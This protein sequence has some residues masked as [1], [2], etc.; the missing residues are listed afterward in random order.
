[1]PGSPRTDPSGHGSPHSP[2]SAAPAL[3]VALDG[4]GGAGKSTVAREV[5]RRRGLR[6][7]DTGSTYR[8][9]TWAVLRAG[10]D[11]ADA[12]AVAALLPQVRIDVTTDAA[13]PGTRVDGL[14]VAAA[15][16]RDDVS[17]GVSAVSAV[18]AVRRALV[19]L[20]QEEVARALAVP[21]LSGEQVGIVVEGRDTGA[22]VVPDA[23][24]KVFLTAD[25]A[26]RAR[27]RATERGTLGADDVRRTAVAL[28]RRDAADSGRAVAPLAVAPG[29][30]VVDTTELSLEEAVSRVLDLLPPPPGAGPPAVERAPRTDPRAPRARAVPAPY[31]PRLFRVL[32]VPSRGL[33]KAAL[34]VQVRGA[35]HLPPSGAVLVAG[36]HSGGLDGPLVAAFAPRLVRILA[37]VE[38]FHGLTG[39]LLDR[40]GQIP[41]DRGHADRAA[42]RASL[43]VLSGGGALGIFPE[44]T[45]GTG[46]LSQ[47]Q[48]G[49]AYLLLRHPCP[50]VPVVC[51]GTA[52]ALPRGAR[53]PRWRAPV[54]VVFGP[55]FSV[56]V[57][58]GSRARSALA[59]VS[60]QVRAG[61]LEH[62]DAVAEGRR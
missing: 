8:A 5:A 25:E 22:V 19:R 45:R 61:L 28:S 16:R 57:P 50:V 21:A 1:M 14:D 60:T 34:R 53:L 13:A 37:K 29:A 40:V 54:G 30:V 6:Y 11:P 10:V 15:I 39:Q 36:V 20:Q 59:Q 23:D 27:R 31:S 24:V 55:A 2:H 41:V 44:G 33:A 35:E 58:T 51:T 46:D 38:L 32:R 49:A 47:V 56:E 18:P 43:A 42:L 4:P 62:R 3:V 12:D 52:A 7:L 48:D 17:S 26:V 9:L